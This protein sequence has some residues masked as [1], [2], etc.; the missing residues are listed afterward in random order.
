MLIYIK[1]TSKIVRFEGMKAF[2]GVD[3]YFL[4]SLN[5]VSRWREALG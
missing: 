1:Y 5:S 4:R 2:G 3:L